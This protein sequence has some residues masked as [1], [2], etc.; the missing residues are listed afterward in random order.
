MKELV[1][2]R[3]S[4]IVEIIQEYCASGS[5]HKCFHKSKVKIKMQVALLFFP[6]QRIIFF[7]S[8]FLYHPKGIGH[9]RMRR[10]QDAKILFS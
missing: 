9:N 5:S 4:D 6:R 2:L 10:R 7:L 8:V 1:A 3:G